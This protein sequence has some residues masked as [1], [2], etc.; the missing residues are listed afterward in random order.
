MYGG[1]KPEPDRCGSA[2]IPVSGYA[3]LPDGFLNWPEII[4]M[5]IVV[6][7]AISR[8]EEFWAS[9]QKNLP[10]LPESGVQ[11]IINVFPNQTMDRCVCLWEADSIGALDGYLR[12]KVGDA[13]NDSFFELNEA[14]AMGLNN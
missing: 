5:L 14:N 10:N 3:C 6:N 12:E 7:H 8:P 1:G 13:S 4:S 2:E 11:R 9:A